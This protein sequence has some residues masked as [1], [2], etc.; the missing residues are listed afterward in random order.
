M[1][2]CG[3]GDGGRRDGDVAPKD[4]FL[5]AVAHDLQA[6]IAAL[7]GSL[8]VLRDRF[9]E[10]A[11]HE[12]EDLLDTMAGAVAEA[13]A[14]LANLFDAERLEH[15]VA[16][17]VRSPTD[18]RALV[19]RVVAAS[20]G[21][22][23]IEIDVDDAVV[24]VDPGLT[25]RMIANLI[26]NALVHTPIGTP[27]TVCGRDEGDHVVLHI[28]DAGPGIP[29]HLRAHVF[30]PFHQGSGRGMGVG[31]HLVREFARLHGGDAVIEDVPTGG[32]SVRVRLPTR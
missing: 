1:G 4:A 15:G 12:V 3:A 28:D 14:V 17:L 9:D 11:P 23:R 32:T 24:D 16:Q 27:I 18:L 21:A 31:L 7:A 8:D 25:E 6:S 29:A 2:G 30:E 26:G 20:S 19:A 10:L 13:G 22:D 5:L